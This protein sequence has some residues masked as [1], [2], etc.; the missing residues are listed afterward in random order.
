MSKP[1][2]ALVKQLEARVEQLAQA[3]QKLKDT[4]NRTNFI[5]RSERFC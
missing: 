5:A 1:T 2:Q 4:L 3:N